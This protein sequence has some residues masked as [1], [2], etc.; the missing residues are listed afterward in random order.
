M[1]T[2]KTLKDYLQQCCE[3]GSDQAG[4]IL[5]DPHPFQPNGEAELYFF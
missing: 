4:I 3:S 5:A 1:S 2:I